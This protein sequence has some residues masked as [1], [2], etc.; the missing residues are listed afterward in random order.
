MS[1]PFQDP[2]RGGGSPGARWLVRH[3]AALGLALV[4]GLGLRVLLLPAVGVRQD[5]DVFALWIHQTVVAPLGELYRTDISFP[6]VMAYVFWAVGQVAPVFGAAVDA[7]TDAARVALKTP[8]V[9]ADLGIAVGV[10]FL[11]RH[12]P[13]WAV[14]AAWIVA[15]FPLF[16]YLSAWWGQFES[17]YVLVGLLAAILAIEGR[18]GLSAIV[19]AIAIMTKPQAL[20]IAIPFAAWYLARI[21]PGGLAR[22]ALIGAATIVVLWLPFAADG[23]PLRYAANL[24]AYQDDDF[25]VLSLRAW[26]PWWIVQ[27]NPTRDAFMSDLLPILGP[28]TPRLIGFVLAALLTI[29]ILVATYRSPTQ[30][31]LLLAI[32]TSVLLAFTVLTTMHERYVY[33]AVVFLLPLLPDVRLRVVWIVLGLLATAN[34]LATAP[35]FPEIRLVFSNESVTSYGWAAAELLVFG[36]CL[37]E[38]VRTARRAPHRSAGQQGTQPITN[39]E[40]VPA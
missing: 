6:P 1:R 15:V 26:N 18:M 10:A 12:R 5:M 2:S 13:R 31:T 24:A 11:L 27:Q 33:A 9:V 34:I 21:G 25:A 7:S 36:V 35:A 3:W 30:R 39:G 38:L 29:P 8:A 17:I 16:W 22:M 4:V 14:L 20:P 32:A 23:G 28:L 19:L 40:Q 37:W